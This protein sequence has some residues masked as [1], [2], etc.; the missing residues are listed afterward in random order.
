MISESLTT[1]RVAAK[2]G[3]LQAQLEH[4][5]AENTPDYQPLTR[6]RGNSLLR[7]YTT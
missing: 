5:P 1:R 6:S 2:L 3:Q 7:S 4:L